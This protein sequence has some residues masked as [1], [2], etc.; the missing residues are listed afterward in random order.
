MNFAP[1]YGR[2][3]RIF[4]RLQLAQVDRVGSFRGVAD[5][6][7]LAQFIRRAHGNGTGRFAV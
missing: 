4:Y 2:I 6:D 5:V 1:R 7:D 3:Q